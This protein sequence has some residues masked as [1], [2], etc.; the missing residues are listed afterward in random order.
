MVSSAAPSGSTLSVT[1][2]VG[3]LASGQNYKWRVRGNDG[4]A[5][6]V[7]GPQTQRALERFQQSQGLQPNG[8]ATPATIQA[9]GLDPNNLAASLPAR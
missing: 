5:D 3:S 4:S 2:P 7:W 1:V 8:Q 9:L 6:G